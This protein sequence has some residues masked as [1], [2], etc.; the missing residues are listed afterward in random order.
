M[1]GMTVKQLVMS[2]LPLQDNKHMQ[3]WVDKGHPLCPSTRGGRML[4]VTSAVNQLLNEGK[5]KRIRRF[6]FGH[7]GWAGHTYFIKDES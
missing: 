5:I 4:D 1:N 3:I 6:G 7:S 2:R